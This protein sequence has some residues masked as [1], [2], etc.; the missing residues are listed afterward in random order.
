M[1]EKTIDG[2][3]V[4]ITVD[5]TTIGRKSGKPRRIEIWSHCFDDRLI[6]TSSP[7]KRSWYANLIANPHFTYHLKGHTHRDVPAIAK[8][9]TNEDERRAILSR[10]K[11]VSPYWDRHMDVIEDWV[12]GS[13]LVEVMLK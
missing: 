9:I 1:N 3:S 5:I 10:L 11:E 4:N 2:L 8:P 6:I 12:Q 7:G 13:C